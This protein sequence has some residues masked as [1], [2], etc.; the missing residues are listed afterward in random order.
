[1]A[2]RDLGDGGP[3][4]AAQREERYEHDSLVG[5][6]VDDLVVGALRQAVAIL[7]G[8]GRDDLPPALDLIDADL[9]KADVAE[10][11][12]VWIWGDRAEAVLEWRLGVAAV[13]VVE[14]ERVGAQ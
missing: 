7:D 2:T 10:L 3:I 6:A 8:R 13:Q 1:M 4:R 14:L 9:R 5:A 12:A 11:S